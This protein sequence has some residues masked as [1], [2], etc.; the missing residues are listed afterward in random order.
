VFAPQVYKINVEIEADE[1]PISWPT[2]LNRQSQNVYSICSASHCFNQSSSELKQG[3]GQRLDGLC[4]DLLQK[5]HHAMPGHW[6]YHG[7]R[8]F[9]RVARR[10][11]MD[12]LQSQ[13][14]VPTHIYDKG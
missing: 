10:L 13:Q 6:V 7:T 14:T 4:N 2:E 12:D 1:G 8:R 5:E 3:Q 11:T 9:L